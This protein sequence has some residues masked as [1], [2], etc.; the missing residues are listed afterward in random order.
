MKDCCITFSK[1]KWKSN[2]PLHDLITTPGSTYYHFTHPLPPLLASGNTTLNHTHY[3]PM[4]F[5]NYHLQPYVLSPPWASGITTFSLTNYYPHWFQA[6]PP[7]T[8]QPV[9][10]CVS[11]NALYWLGL[12]LAQL[13]DRVFFLHSKSK[14]FHL[15]LTFLVWNRTSCFSVAA[16]LYMYWCW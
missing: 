16:C 6:L 1:R 13:W 7:S 10:T 3:P 12:I 14:P 11:V 4:G 5:R 15:W 8:L 2:N 9:Q